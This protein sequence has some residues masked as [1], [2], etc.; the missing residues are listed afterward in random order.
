MIGFTLRFKLDNP[1]TRPTVALSL[2]CAVLLAISAAAAPAQTVAGWPANG[3]ATGTP[4]DV[5][6]SDSLLGA[7]DQRV[8][9]GS[10][11]YV[12][13]MVVVRNGKLVVNERYE[14]DYEDIS[15]GRTSPIGCG[16]DAC[17][18]TISEDDPFNYLHPS[19]HPYFQGRD[20]H[21]LQSI[22][23]SV[24]ATIVGVAL[25]R[26]DRGCGRPAVITGDG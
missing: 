4:A 16:I 18:G 1:M 25:Q 10:F 8:R 20:V 23:K 19:T 13:R 22:T 9:Q 2:S 21:S 24:T 7:L 6:L 12:D 3:W 17:T 5:G 15:R 11:G 14:N 26:G